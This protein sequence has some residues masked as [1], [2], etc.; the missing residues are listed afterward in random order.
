MMPDA[1]HWLGVTKIDRFISMSDMKYDAIVA[2]GIKIVER[3]PIPPELVPKDAQ[4]EIAAKVYV[5]Y[6][7]GDQYKVS[8][9]DLKAVKGRA[10]NEY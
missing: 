1:L 8:E 10:T 4:V 6:H 9:Q 7:G 3:V 5:G 2:S